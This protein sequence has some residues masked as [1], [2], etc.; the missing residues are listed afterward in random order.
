MVNRFDFRIVG[1][2]L[3]DDETTTISDPFLITT[4]GTSYN[5]LLTKFLQG[6]SGTIEA[7]CTA[8]GNYQ[9][10]ASVNDLASLTGNSA[11]MLAF[12]VCDLTLYALWRRRPNPRPI[13]E[14]T[15]QA[16]EDLNRIRSGEWIFGLVEHQLAGQMNE[17]VE[18]PSQVEARHG[19]VQEANRF[20]S[21]RN[22]QDYSPGYG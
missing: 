4:V 20:F 13:P 10:N 12:M 9:I 1:E 7:A 8:A 19:P 2:L 6:E 21:R 5:T 18:S 15:Q 3:V 11:Q 14:M 22:N 17:L 16:R